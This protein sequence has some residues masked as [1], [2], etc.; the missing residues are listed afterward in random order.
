MI[1]AHHRAGR[2]AATALGLLLAG[3]KLGPEYRAPALEMPADWRAETSGGP[4]WP[5]STW[6]KGFSSRD[7]DQLESAT[8]VGN[9]DIQAA[10]ARVR[11][12]DAQVRIAGAPLL[13]A[14]DATSTA[15]W[16]RTGFT[17]SKSSSRTST[18][19]AVTATSSRSSH[20]VESRFYDLGLNVSYE[21]DF[22]GK[23]RAQ[24]ESAEAS[25]LFSRYDQ[26]TVALTAVAGVATTWFTALAFKDRVDVAERNLRVAEEV[27]RAFQGRL[28]AGTASMLDVAQQEAL[29]AGVR[30]E[31]PPLRS[32]LEQ[33]LNGL[34][35][36]TGRPPEA[37]TVRP[38]TLT[39][40]SLPLVA[41]GLPS[42]LLARRPDVASAEAQLVAANANIRVARAAFFPDIS[43]TASGGWQSLALSTLWG[44][45]S[46]FA[47]A[48]ASAA[49]T[50][51]DNGA[52]GGQYELNKARYDELVADY[53][54]AVVQAF[55]DVEN[56]L[57][58]LRY[59]TE[60]EERE[61]QAVDTAQRAA[62][63]ARAQMQAG[64]I[65]IVTALQV[66]TTLFTDLDL[67]VQARLA[68]FLALVD[69]YKAL[70]G[71]WTR[72]D[73]VAP[74]STIFHGVL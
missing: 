24:Q 59:A 16:S 28:A 52:I 12:A 25:A 67:L 10:I 33:E 57:V 58:A 72:S 22:W 38:G 18:S 63:I 44:P 42:E 32:Q 47:N 56:A 30:A 8:Q 71:G 37:I 34:G 5:S 41:P 69:L 27:L 31:I 13:P 70:G 74:P 54:K 62:D 55:T 9:F 6:W 17:S 1:H 53:R 43:L 23:L 4:L 7:L 11:Q 26:Q 50:V 40:L 19:G 36:L 66:Q 61:R 3:C 20:Y 45:G 49:Q 65:D 39:N 46:L 29:V 51:F 68:R 15:S 73:V 64:T 60:Q 2:L 48:A 14:V 21:V 35:I